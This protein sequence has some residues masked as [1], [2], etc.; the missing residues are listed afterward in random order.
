MKNSVKTRTTSICREVYKPI[1]RLKDKRKR[2]LTRRD[3]LQSMLHSFTEIGS[4]DVLKGI[5]LLLLYLNS[6][7]CVDLFVT[8]K[9]RI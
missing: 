7:A 8:W 3:D 6:R 4:I 1:L 5:G 9:I 2:R